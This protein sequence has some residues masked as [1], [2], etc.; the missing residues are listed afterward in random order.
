[1][2]INYG[3][4]ENM[5]VS[6]AK[7]KNCLPELVRAVEQGEQVVITRH[8][9]PVAQIVS[10]P[11]GRRSVRLGAMAGRIRFKPGWDAAID[12]DRFVAGDL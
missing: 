8:G 2:A 1:M 7:A 6:V 11:A 12:P 4:N 10:A 9:K 3:H 5:D